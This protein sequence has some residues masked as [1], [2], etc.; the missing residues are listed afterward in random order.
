MQRS[1]WVVRSITPNA[2]ALT[3]KLQ[4]FKCLNLIG[5]EGNVMVYRSLFH[6]CTFLRT[7][8]SI[9]TNQSGVLIYLSQ[10]PSMV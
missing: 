8:I 2:I 5:T 3:C 7:K 10:K 1:Q 4:L 6:I 9:V